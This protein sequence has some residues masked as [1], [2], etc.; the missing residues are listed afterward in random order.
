VRVLEA[1]HTVHTES[2]E[3]TSA[4][5]RVDDGIGELHVDLHGRRTPESPEILTPTSISGD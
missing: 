1:E 4:V 2:L 3:C 5:G